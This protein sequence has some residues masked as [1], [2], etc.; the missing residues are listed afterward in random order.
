MRRAIEPILASLRRAVSP[1]AGRQQPK[2]F[3]TTVAVDRAFRR[4]IGQCIYCGSTANLTEEHVVPYGL[5]GHRLILEDA[6]CRPC[7]KTTGAFEGAVLRGFMLKARTVA[8]LPTRRLRERPKAFTLE[9]G[10]GHNLQ[11]FTIPV[12]D[13]PALLQLP[14]LPRAGF[15]A[16][17]PYCE[18]LSIN[19]RDI[20]H[21]GKD[22]GEVAKDLGVG[23][24]QLSDWGNIQAFSRMLAKIGYAFAVFERGPIPRDEVPVL[25]LILGTA[26]N[27]SAWVGSAEYQTEME[28]RGAPWVLSAYAGTRLDKRVTVARVKLFANTGTTGYEVVVRRSRGW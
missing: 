3:P 24:I 27:G 28:K 5:A 22:L 18:G 10:D 4:P 15:L 26:N 8:G 2:T 6:S 21:F 19:G 16:E 17:R 12:A 11:T 1:F 23:S 25:P 7:A 20:L 9:A 13:Y 14:R